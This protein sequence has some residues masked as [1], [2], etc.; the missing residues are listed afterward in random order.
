MLHIHMCDKF[1]NVIKQSELHVPT[2][3]TTL[4]SVKIIATLDAI[5]HRYLLQLHAV[6]ITG[7][8]QN[9]YINIS[10]MYRRF[11]CA[12]KYHIGYRLF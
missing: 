1:V 9:K 2:F 5:K 11:L 7:E 6:H 10:C 8:I 12:F 3:Q 4:T